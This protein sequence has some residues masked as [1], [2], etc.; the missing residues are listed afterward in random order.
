LNWNLCADRKRGLRIEDSAIKLRTNQ[1]LPKAAK[2]R[3]WAG[4][5]PEKHKAHRVVSGA[6][7]SGRI[8]RSV[9][10]QLCLGIG[11]IEAHHEDYSKPLE[12]VWI[13]HFCHGVLSGRLPY[14]WDQS[15]ET[16]YA[17]AISLRNAGAS[18]RT[19]S[20]QVGF[21]LSTVYK[22]MHPGLEYD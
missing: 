3:R 8:T 20:K 2:N 15:R 18:Y 4:A 16:I 11:R 21:S 1:M 17:E 19:I 12:I 10:C 14:C 6:I 7:R 9:F 13:C 22:I 5:N